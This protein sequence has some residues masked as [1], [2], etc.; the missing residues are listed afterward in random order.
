MNEVVILTVAILAVA[1]GSAGIAI[2]VQPCCAVGSSGGWS[3][4]DLLNN[5]GSSVSDNQ[6]AK[7]AGPS[8]SSE[9]VESEQGILIQSSQSPIRT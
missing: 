1:L 3:G 8:A 5:M 7:I 6:Q 2:G 4:E 9:P